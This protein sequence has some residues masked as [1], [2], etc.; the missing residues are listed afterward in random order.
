[1]VS[2]MVDY[3]KKHGAR[4][5]TVRVNKENAAS[6]KIVRKLGF[7]AVGEKRYKKHGT[8]LEFCDYSYELRC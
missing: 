3:A 1:M 8:E 5:V 2:G 4:K 7:E 6:N